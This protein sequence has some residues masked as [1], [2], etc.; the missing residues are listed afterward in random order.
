MK[1]RRVVRMCPPLVVTEKDINLVVQ[2][3]EDAFNEDIL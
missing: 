3:I 1:P 2:T